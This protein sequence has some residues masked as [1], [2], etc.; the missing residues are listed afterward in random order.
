MKIGYCVEDSTTRA[1]LEGLR[2]R[3]CPQASFV[4]SGR[5]RGQTLRREIPK[6]CVEL[7]SKGADLVVLLR[8]SN[9]ENWRDVLKDDAGR[10]D[11]A[12]EHGTVFG[13]CDRN[14]ECWLAASP[15]W[16]A[17]RTDQS[18]EPFRADDPKR[19]VESAL[20]VGSL[21]RREEEIAQLVVD[22]PLR[23]WLRNRSFEDFYDKLWRKSKDLDCSLENL[24]Q[25]STP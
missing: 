25:S 24:R 14:V 6:I 17:R 16:L 7:F 1:L 3:W 20:K 2:R 22:A 13:V 4:P 11:P 9:L 19:A 8:D 12:H 18:R 15:D 21:D 10:C 5:F 23:D